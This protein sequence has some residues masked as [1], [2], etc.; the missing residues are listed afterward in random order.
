MKRYCMILSVALAVLRVHAVLEEASEARARLCII[1][2]SITAITF[3]AQ[4][5]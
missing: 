3:V 4:S 2:A 1:T 5:W